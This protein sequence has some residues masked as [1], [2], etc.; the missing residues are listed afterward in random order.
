MLKK[1]CH[2]PRCSQRNHLLMIEWFL[3]LVSVWSPLDYQLIQPKESMNHMRR[4]V[5]SINIYSSSMFTN[6]PPICIAEICRTLTRLKQYDL[7]VSPGPLF[8]RITAA[9]QGFH[10]YSRCC[11]LGVLCF[12]CCCRALREQNNCWR[13]WCSHALRLSLVPRMC[14]LKLLLSDFKTCHSRDMSATLHI[15]FVSMIAWPCPSGFGSTANTANIFRV[16]IFT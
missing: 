2:R 15:R 12:E 7:I 1:T 6:F 9:K 16:P 8:V 5:E 4:A 14:H 3:A 13:L 11:I 10:R